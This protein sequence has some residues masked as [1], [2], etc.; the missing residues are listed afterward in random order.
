M[1]KEEPPYEFKIHLFLDGP[2][3]NRDR[4]EPSN[5][6]LNLKVMAKL[7]TFGARRIRDHYLTA[8]DRIRFVFDIDDRAEALNCYRFF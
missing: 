2:K 5:R 8:H 7:Q 6:D 3:D 4:A 1:K